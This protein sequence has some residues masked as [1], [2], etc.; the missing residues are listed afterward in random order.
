MDSQALG[1]V[2]TIIINSVA[3]GWTI[4][5]TFVRHGQTK[6]LQESNAKLQSEVH[7]LSVHLN[8]EIVRLN[9]LNELTRDMYVNCARL[10]HQFS[11]RRKVGV[12]DIKLGGLENKSVDEVAEF[13]ISVRGSII[14]MRAIANVIGDPE[15]QSLV[16]QMRSHIPVEMAEDPDKSSKLLDEFG[17]SATE[18]LE[19]VYRLLQAATAA[20]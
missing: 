3:I 13:L 18:L 15:L 5:E 10:N 9:R 6:E 12:D 20:A 17:K 14:E 4:R 16:E 2:A 7:R 8:Q 11:L 19:K 1:I